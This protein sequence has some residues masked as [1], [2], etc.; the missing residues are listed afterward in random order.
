MRTAGECRQRTPGLGDGKDNI[1]MI[2]DKIKPTP[3]SVLLCNQ[4]FHIQKVS[5][6]SW[7]VQTSQVSDIISTLW[8][9]FCTGHS[10]IKENII[11]AEGG[12]KPHRC[13]SGQNWTLATMESTDSS[14]SSME[15]NTSLRQRSHRRSRNSKMD[16][17]V[18]TT[19][20]KNGCSTYS[21]SWMMW[22]WGHRVV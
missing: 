8:Q 1:R 11:T 4:I 3:R 2:A 16:S 20:R 21:R 22:Y 6:V 14:S 13:W 15:R 17:L 19:L 18:R 12:D 7:K 9:S 5:R 10:F